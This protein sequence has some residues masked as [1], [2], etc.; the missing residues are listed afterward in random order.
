MKVEINR[1]DLEHLLDL[2]IEGT[3]IWD[4]SR[5]PGAARVVHRVAKGLQAA[6]T[7]PELKFSYRYKRTLGSLIESTE[8]YL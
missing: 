3:D 8:D 5:N 1:D 2:V 7:D 6:G 4:D